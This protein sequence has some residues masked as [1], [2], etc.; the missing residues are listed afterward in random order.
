ME[1]GGPILKRGLAKPLGGGT[2]DNLNGKTIKAG[3]EQDFVQDKNAKNNGSQEVLNRGVG[4]CPYNPRKGKWGMY[5]KHKRV[6]SSKNRTEA[7]YNFK[8]PSS[9]AIKADASYLDGKKKEHIEEEEEHGRV[10][11]H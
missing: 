7:D 2:G 6:S 5:Q 8:R 11:G 4:S 1:D 9:S 3:P 10:L